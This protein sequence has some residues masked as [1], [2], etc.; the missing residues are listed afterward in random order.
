VLV[1]ISTSGKS[2]SILK[3]I[4]AARTTGAKIVGLTGHPGGDMPPVCDSCIQVPSSYT[5]H[6]QE[7]HGVVIHI[8]CKIVEAWFGVAG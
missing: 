6:I 8:L 4:E 3:A 5:P 1:A 7:A 2:P